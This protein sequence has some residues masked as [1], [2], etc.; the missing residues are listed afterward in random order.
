M[1]LADQE[2]RSRIDLFTPYSQSITDRMQIVKLA[3]MSYGIIAA[4]DLV[5]R[6][7]CILYQVVQCKPVD[8]KH[9]EAFTRLVG[10]ADMDCVATIWHE[11]KDD[12]HPHDLSEALTG[13]QQAIT[14]N[15]HLLQ[16][17]VYSQAIDQ[18]CPWC[19]DSEVFPLTPAARIHEV[20][21]YV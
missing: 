9:S 17:D 2:S 1:Q 7:L 5:A 19:R 4:E 16:P 21:G 13:M 8:P 11:Y 18:T 20:W 6:L 3:G 12:W 14:K 15:A 10:L